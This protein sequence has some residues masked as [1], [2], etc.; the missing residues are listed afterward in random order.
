MTEPLD[1]DAYLNRIAW[2]RELRCDLATLAALAAHHA[3]AIPFENITPFLGD[4]VPLDL[5]AVQR[6]LV[7]DRR[8]GYCFEQNLLLSQV[9]QHLG[10]AVT[11]LAARVLWGQSEDTIGARSHML[12]LVELPEGP[13]LVD[14]GFGGLTLT[15]AL[16]LQA[17][18][19]QATPHET[20]RLIVVDGDWRMQSKLNGEWKSLYRFDLQRQFAPD[21]EVS[22]HYVSTFPGSQF[23]HHLMA[24]RALPGMRLALRDREFSVHRLHGGSERRL[25]ASPREVSE[26][27]SQEFRIALPVGDALEHRLWP[28]FDRT[29]AEN[30]HPGK[31]QQAPP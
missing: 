28:F 30:T 5:P 22:N 8:G 27:L 1:L 6:K 21:Y 7:H 18:V 25:L 31:S 11:G 9:L 20:F 23:I 24:A 14:V 16:R 17:D 15:G 12:L 10:F 19:E 3:A 26:L 2:T 4:P 29:T 13:H